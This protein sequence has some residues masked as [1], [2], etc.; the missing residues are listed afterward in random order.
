MLLSAMLG[1][2][3]VLEG[4]KSRK[5][6]IIS[7]P[8]HPWKVEDWEK[9]L[10]SGLKFCLPNEFALDSGNTQDAILDASEQALNEISKHPPRE[11]PAPGSGYDN[12]EPRSGAMSPTGP[13]E[14]RVLEEAVDNQVFR[15]LRQMLFIP[16]LHTEYRRFVVLRS[17]QSIPPEKDLVGECTLM[18][19]HFC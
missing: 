3:N 6:S 8:P 7:A 15:D 11:E 17:S 1:L 16:I 19:S 4:V 2:L 14:G 13:Y 9:W 10:T 5:I 18:W 12:L